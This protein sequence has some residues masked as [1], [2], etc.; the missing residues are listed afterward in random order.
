[1]NFPKFPAALQ[2]QLEDEIVAGKLSCNQVV[3]LEELS[4]QFKS[5]GA[6]IQ[7]VIPSMERWI[8]LCS[9]GINQI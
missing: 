3:T 1:V 4:H 9:C 7:Q 6:E 5:S 2:R 8:Y